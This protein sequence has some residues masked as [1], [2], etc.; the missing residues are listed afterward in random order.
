K[1]DEEKKKRDEERRQKQLAD[2][3]KRDE[4]KKK[5]DEER[6][7]K[8][9][10]EQETKRLKEQLDR[11]LADTDAIARREQDELERSRASSRASNATEIERVK[12]LIRDKV[13]RE[14]AWGGDKTKLEVK[15]RINL[16]AN[17]DILNLQKIGASGDS[18]FDVSVSQAILLAE[19]L[20][21]PKDE[22]LFRE[23]FDPLDI[24]F[25]LD[26]LRN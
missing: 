8:Q 7:Q 13:K 11:A 9:L 2:Q 3:K 16:S 18:S 19:P 22:L 14:W 5:R 20:P 6:R 26:E 10:V 12:S 15:Y 24:R 4:E 23:N 17:G 25:T 1:R 21:V